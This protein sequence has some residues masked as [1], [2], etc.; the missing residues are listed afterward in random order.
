MKL[1]LVEI[2]I[3]PGVFRGAKKFEAFFAKKASGGQAS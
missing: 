3:A 2:I 1:K